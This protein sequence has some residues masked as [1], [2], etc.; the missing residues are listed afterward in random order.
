MTK[1]YTYRWLVELVVRR[2]GGGL[3]DEQGNALATLRPIMWMFC[4]G[5]TL[6][7]GELDLCGG[8]RCRV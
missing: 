6:R 1:G 3:Y 4:H 5:R 2:G 7:K 8:W